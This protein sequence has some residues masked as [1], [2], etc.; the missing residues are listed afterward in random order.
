MIIQR[1]YKSASNFLSNILE[2]SS[3]ISNS[4]L[5]CA[6]KHLVYNPKPSASS[7]T[8]LTFKLLHSSIAKHQSQSNEAIYV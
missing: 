5:Y 3:V 6:N 4:H 7:S 8:T 1:Y 2:T